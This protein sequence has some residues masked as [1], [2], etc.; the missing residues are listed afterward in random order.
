[1]YLLAVLISLSYFVAWGEE[2]PRRAFAALYLLFQFME[3][4]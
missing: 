4:Q 1:M 2:T 3:A